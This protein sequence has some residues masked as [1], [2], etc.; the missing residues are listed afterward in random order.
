MTW[1]DVTT[2][3]TAVLCSLLLMTAPF[4]TA[5]LVHADIEADTDGNG[6]FD[7]TIGGTNS[8]MLG[9]PYDSGASDVVPVSS[10]SAWGGILFCT[11]VTTGTVEWDLPSAVTGMI[12]TA[13]NYNSGVTAV[14]DPN[15]SDQIYNLTDTGGDSIA[16][17]TQGDVVTLKC[18]MSGVWYAVSE[19][20]T[21]SD[22]N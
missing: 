1:K 17:I 20:G 7:V 18:I 19:T 10:T 4:M 12:V 16:N 2:W 21:W 15:G 13:L 9:D 22:N 6:L 11:G 8:A 3:G 14:L 5:S